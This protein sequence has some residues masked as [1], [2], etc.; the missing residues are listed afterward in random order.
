LKCAATICLLVLG[1]A[2]AAAAQSASSISRTLLILPLENSSKASG[3]EWIGESFP[4]VLGDRMASP[5]VYVVSRADRSYA[6]DRAGIPA[7]IHPSHA[8]LFRIGEELDADYLV[9]GQ[10]SYDGHTFTAEAQLLDLKAMRLQPPITESGPLTSLFAIETALA[11]D[12]TRSISPDFSVRREA[13]MQVSAP[14]RLDAF[15]NYIRGITA[16][17]RTEKIR[18]LR[19]ALKADPAY[20]Q[21]MMQLARTYFSGHNYDAAASWFTRVPHSDPAA[22]EASFYAGLAYFYSGDCEKAAASF[23]YL[24]SLFA[25]TE[26]YNNLGVTA[27]CRNKNKDAL[28]YFQKAVQADDHDPDYRFNLAVELD[29]SGDAA[30]AAR[31]LRE[32][33]QLRP[34]DAEAELFLEALGKGSPGHPPAERI[35]RNYDESSFQQMQLEIRNAAEVRLAKSD[36]ATHAAWHVQHGHE[37]LRQNFVSEAGQDFREAISLDPAN[38][39]AHAGLAVVLEA[40][41]DRGGARREATAALRLKPLAEAYLVLAR[42]DWSDHKADSAAQNVDR[43]LALDPAS[44]AAAELKRTI[45]EGKS[46]P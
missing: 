28:E 38:A 34:S 45:A 30:A 22:R 8:T 5:T 14:T 9:F 17:D 7:N 32:A 43:A 36:A 18:R 16:A 21:A 20:T 33:V 6:F 12:L 31:E 39:G 40:G 10:Y 23:G 27:A 35:K 25:L 1:V 41:N 24:A 29:K 15:E 42:L 4:E 11:W 46:G 37:L 2:A 19:E 13:F 26:V 3:I 44:A